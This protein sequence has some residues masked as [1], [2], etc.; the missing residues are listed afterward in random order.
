MRRFTKTSGRGLQVGENGRISNGEHECFHCAY[1]RS[2]PTK[3]LAPTPLAVWWLGSLK[4]LKM[5][6]GW[7][8]ELQY[9]PDHELPNDILLRSKITVSS[10][11]IRP[12]PWVK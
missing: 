3:K 9:L 7:G 5:G 1:D 6:G 12:T 8:K 11:S 4:V 10:R 2:L